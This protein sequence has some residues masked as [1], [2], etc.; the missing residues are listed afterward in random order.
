MA[1][2]LNLGVW[3]WIK[4]AMRQV[5]KSL[6]LETTLDEIK[7][8]IADLGDLDDLYLRDFNSIHR[9]CK[10][11]AARIFLISIHAN[12]PIPVLTLYLA[13][14]LTNSAHTAIFSCSED[15]LAS[16]TQLQALLADPTESEESRNDSLGDWSEGRIEVVINQQHKQVQDR[17]LDFMKI[18]RSTDRYSAALAI[19][20]RLVFCHRTGRDFLDRQYDRLLQTVN[21]SFKINEVL[22][23]AY[24]LHAHFVPK[25]MTYK[26][27]ALT[28]LFRDILYC[29]ALHMNSRGGTAARAL[30]WYPNIGSDFTAGTDLADLTLA[31]GPDV[32]EPS[33]ES[34]ASS[35]IGKESISSSKGLLSSRKNTPM[36]KNLQQKVASKIES[37]GD[38][39]EAWNYQRDAGIV[40]RFMH[41]P[42]FTNI[43][44]SD[45]PTPGRQR[46]Q[47]ACLAADATTSLWTAVH[48]AAS[49]LFLTFN[50]ETL[51]SQSEISQQRGKSSIWGS[52]LQILLTAKQ[53]LHGAALPPM[54][55]LLTHGMLHYGAGPKYVLHKR[56]SSNGEFSFSMRNTECPGC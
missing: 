18:R 32:E 21:S 45:H 52:W 4:H 13:G 43:L 12:E 1:N 54:L 37:W 51:R 25:K 40:Q 14:F 34:D 31:A 48:A 35:F 10:Q 20:D 53:N 23:K 33:D 19:R 30:D 44:I 28:L 9:D 22:L 8:S 5:F 49:L 15:S 29:A 39:F 42:K 24:A 41:D 38:R 17:V 47:A 6:E 2:K 7:K 16:K 50:S 3:I 56:A 36:F 11:Q 26:R 55:R 46:M 27:E